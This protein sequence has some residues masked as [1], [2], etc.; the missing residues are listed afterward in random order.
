M[1]NIKKQLAV[2]LALIIAFGLLPAAVFAYD[3]TATTQ[4]IDNGNND[5]IVRGFIPTA[6]S[7]VNYGNEAYYQLVDGKLT[8][9]D[10]TK[11]CMVGIGSGIYIE[12]ESSVAFVPT[13]YILTTGNDTAAEGDENRNPKNWKVLAKVNKDD[14]RWTELSIV[15]N[16]TVMQKENYASFTF[17]LNQI[18]NNQK[19]YKYFKF[20]V[21]AVQSGST[22][23]LSEF[24]F[25]GHMDD[26]SD[27][28]Y[29]TQIQNGV[30]SC[31]TVT[32]G[33]ASGWHLVGNGSSSVEVVITE[34]YDKLVDGKRE[35]KC[36]VR[37]NGGSFPLHIHV[38]FESSFAFV[39]TGYILTTGDDTAFYYGRNPI[40][41]TIEARASKDDGWTT[42]TDESNNTSLPASNNEPT[43]FNFNREGGNTNAYK[44]FRFEVS[45]VQSGGEFQLSE[46]QFKGY[47]SPYDLEAATVTG[48]GTDYAYDAGTAH[49]ITPAAASANGTAL[50]FGTD[51]TLTLDGADVG[52]IPFSVTAPG[53][54]TLVFAGTGTEAAGYTGTKTVRFS[55]TPPELSTDTDYALNE[56]GFYYINM[57]A[58]GTSAE[59]PSTFTASNGYIGSL[60][61]Y[62][63]GGKSGPYTAPYD[64]WL[65]LTAP[66]EY[67]IRLSGSL[68]L[69]GGE[70]N[71]SLYIYDGTDQTTP[72][73]GFTSS[74]DIGEYCSAGQSV[75][76]HF[77]ST[78]NS[79]S[80]AGL[81][82]SV[83]FLSPYILSE[84]SISGIA[85]GYLNT[86][87]LSVIENAVK[88][89]DRFGNLISEHYSVAVTKQDGD[90]TPV[91]V[92]S[93]TDTGWYTVTVTGV[94]P[95]TGSKSK[96]FL[97]YKAVLGKNDASEYLIG[98]DADW[99]TFAY[100]I[101]HDNN[102]A[103]YG[104]KTFKLTNDVTVYATVGV[105]NSTG[106]LYTHQF[107]ATF[108]GDG[109][110]I[111]L[112][113]G[114]GTPF[115]YVKSS[116]FKNVTV[117]GVFDPGN[118]STGTD[119]GL[120]SLISGI[121]NVTNCRVSASVYSA[122]AN[123]GGFVGLLISP[124][125]C[126]FENC[127]FDGKLV[128]VN[129]AA[130]RGGFVGN[131]PSNTIL[132][133]TNCLY[134][135]AELADGESEPAGSYTFVSGRTVSFSTCYYTRLVNN[136]SAGA[137]GKPALTNEP[138][139]Q[140]YTKVTVLGKEVY[141]V[142]EVAV[143]DVWDYT[144]SDLHQNICNGVSVTYGG[145][146]LA[147]GTDYNIYLQDNVTALGSY[148]LT[149]TG[150]NQNGSGWF[151]SKTVSFFVINHLSGSGTESGPYLIASVADWD[152]F[153]SNVNAG[154]SY[155]GEYVAL[156]AN[157]T[158]TS[159]VGN[160]NNRFS[161]TFTGLYN[162]TIHTL[163]L[164]YT[165]T[166][167][168]TAPF[169][170][171]LDA[172]IKDL[173][174]DGTITTSAKC[175]AGVAGKIS[176]N[177]LIENCL[178][179]V[180][181][182]S[183]VTGSNPDGTH[184]GF[185]GV[186]NDYAHLTIQGC[187]F[188]G[189]MLYTGDSSAS[190]ITDH[191]GGFI[192][193]NSH[194]ASTALENCLYAPAALAE[195]E[196][197][198][199]NPDSATFLRGGGASLTRCFYLATLNEAQGMSAHTLT[200]SENVQLT[201]SADS[202]VYSASGLTVNSSFGFTYNSVSYVG[203]GQTVSLTV[204]TPEGYVVDTVK[205]TYNNGT[206]HEETPAVTDSGAYRF[207][208]PGANTAVTAIVVKAVP[209]MAYS[210]AHIRGQ[211]NTDSK[212]DIRFLFVLTLNKAKIK[213]DGQWYGCT[214]DDCLYELR[215]FEAKVSNAD[216]ET[217]Y[218]DWEQFNNIYSVTGNTFCTVSIVLANV[219]WSM[220]ATQFK[221]ETRYAYKELDE[222]TAGFHYGG[223]GTE[224]I[225][226]VHN[227]DGP[228]PPPVV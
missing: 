121:V 33:T 205:Y 139:D 95:Y 119:A 99:L 223:Y 51:Y 15:E 19:A 175:G 128:S 56:T 134:S 201:P 163:T 30:V 43:E 46:L 77:N 145:A 57:P 106:D 171:I 216:D 116:T 102:G 176:G 75:L 167:E 24:E 129:G 63:D 206:D 132:T 107:S 220:Q 27:P 200:Y 197:S 174:V 3:S 67:R 34:G 138:S 92:F 72:L 108:D 4:F 222:Q 13:G 212:N 123:C 164:N 204:D 198:V 207:A 89:K 170:H 45:A 135:P 217:V 202:A 81:E 181:I 69:G 178:S 85:V 122:K 113:P 154:Y 44:Y 192:G 29:T 87:A 127:I 49:S 214:G 151:G 40:S 58:A 117:E 193:W 53:I 65:L 133:F 74:G 76:I 41:W 23:Q 2:L 196:T 150:I 50:T 82:L 125:R 10:G 18:P 111:T 203:A 159:M 188:N 42:L 226:G 66:A 194:S 131:N 190:N 215:G 225:E 20:E 185:V 97:V 177:C 199:G 218:F 78:A 227:S 64:G 195:G 35:T 52:S 71:A 26:P 88:V 187:V 172:T 61:V 62:D 80:A 124:S 103:V 166:E 191:C 48:V 7:G 105:S 165:N 219:P 17:A 152:K 180:T 14:E 39:P 84:G 73:C 21:S 112:I 96:D 12:F 183:T 224:S 5:Y 22:F 136:E 68:E 126:C 114:V 162:N 153:A 98:S 86:T 158:V 47:R 1:K 184:G 186:V 210:T 55:V 143:S 60:K 228:E 25:I 211:Y 32:E 148:S 130:N 157:I 109:H 8:P 9:E 182:N 156:N 100:M 6:G 160:E 38:E 147:N 28:D 54:H 208:M 137:Q 141:P 213:I 94:S 110:T 79:G 168:F 155:S 101:N 37:E 93:D 31:F 11:W 146:N 173:R 90:G 140:L 115:G 161:G 189:K 70:N 120:I 118:S 104:G 179:S 59:G 149:V 221:V 209:E 36:C 169:R 16:D 83:E 91:T 142:A 144:G